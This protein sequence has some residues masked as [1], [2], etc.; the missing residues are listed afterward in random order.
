MRSFDYARTLPEA[1]A[2]LPVFVVHF[3]VVIMAR[4]LYGQFGSASMAFGQELPIKR[5]WR[6]AST[7]LKPASRSRNK[8]WHEPSQSF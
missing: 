1:Q 2:G 3:A 7:R 8:R 6:I 5:K 4:N